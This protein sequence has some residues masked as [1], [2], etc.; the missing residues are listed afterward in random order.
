MGIPVSLSTG[1]TAGRVWLGDRSQAGIVQTAGLSVLSDD[2]GANFDNNTVTYK[3][4]ARVNAAILRPDAFIYG[5][6]NGTT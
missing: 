2:K 1:V 4:E 5:D 6:L 3:A